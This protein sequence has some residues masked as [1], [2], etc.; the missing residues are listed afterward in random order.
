M[1]NVVLNLGVTLAQIEAGVLSFAHSTRRNEF[2]QICKERRGQRILLELSDRKRKPISLRIA[3]EDADD[4]NRG[5]NE[6]RCL[7][8]TGTYVARLT[9][10][11]SLAPLNSRFSMSQDLEC[12]STQ[13]SKASMASDEQ[14]IVS[15]SADCC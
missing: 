9:K 11:R 13:Y 3:T 15:P 12:A 4:V 8:A 1:M 5:S 7:G 6:N 10:S 14:I 2:H